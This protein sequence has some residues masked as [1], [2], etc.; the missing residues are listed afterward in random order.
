MNLRFWFSIS[1]KNKNKYLKKN[2][3]N[4]EQIN[5]IFSYSYQI[6]KI[7]VYYKKF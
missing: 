6:K 1:F 5:T 3:I 7:A 2:K 4:L